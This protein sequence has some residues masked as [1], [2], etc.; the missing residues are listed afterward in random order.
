MPT[1]SLGWGIQ[2][3]AS[4][5][6]PDLVMRAFQ[7]GHT[8]HLMGNPAV[9]QLYVLAYICVENATGLPSIGHGGAIT[10]SDISA[11]LCGLS[12]AILPPNP[13]LN[14]I[15]AIGQYIGQAR[16]VSQLP[17]LNR[18]IPNVANVRAA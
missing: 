13:R 15:T 10:P 16:S 4:D 2:K 7:S 9:I 1:C 14:R 8:V 17:I 5:L 11:T 12:L 18:N 6:K 3:M